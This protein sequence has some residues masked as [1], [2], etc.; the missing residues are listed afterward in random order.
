M[1]TQKGI[2]SIFGIAL[3]SVILVAGIYLYMNNEPTGQIVGD[4]T[5]QETPIVATSTDD[6]DTDRITTKMGVSLVLPTGWAVE[7]DTTAETLIDSDPTAN[8]GD[9]VVITLHETAKFEDFDA[10]FGK[11]ALEHDPE[12]A[13]W[14]VTMAD[15]R[16]G[17]YVTN[18]V[19]QEDRFVDGR[20]AFITTQRWLTY[21]VVRGKNTFVE[22]NMTGSGDTAALGPLLDSV[23]FE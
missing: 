16:T 5:N 6:I 17:E 15:Q 7:T 14:L 21:V 12:Q 20:P 18:C 10:K 4:T 19:I 22:F 2:S 3:I 1:N 23:R 8:L 9:R 13:C 11:F